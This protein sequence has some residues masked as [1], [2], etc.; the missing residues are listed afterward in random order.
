MIEVEELGPET[1]A[2]RKVALE[3]QRQGKIPKGPILAV[4]RVN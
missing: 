1:Y 2:A 4:V 3:R